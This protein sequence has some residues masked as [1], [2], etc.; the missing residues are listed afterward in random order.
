[1]WQKNRSQANS[2]NNLSDDDDV[3]LLAD[4]VLSDLLKETNRETME[5]D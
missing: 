4:H 1:M 5:M 3:K 2:G